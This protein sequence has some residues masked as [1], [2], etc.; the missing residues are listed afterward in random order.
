M[1]KGAYLEAFHAFRDPLQA[2]VSCVTTAQITGAWPFPQ[3]R[4]YRLSLSDERARLGRR[5]TLYF[6]LAH[7][8]RIEPQTGGVEPWRIRT[9]SYSYWLYGGEGHELV[10][11]QWAPASPSPVRTPH[12]HVG[13]SLAHARLPEPFRGHVQRL[14]DTHLPTGFIPFSSILHAVMNDFG[15]IPLRED[16]GDVERLLNAADR[17]LRASFVDE[18]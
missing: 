13:R 8:Y 10:V 4:E 3:D 15:L 12:L 11:Y 16:R 6:A 17:V 2:A 14:V 9:T 7:S 5:S 1:T 18:A